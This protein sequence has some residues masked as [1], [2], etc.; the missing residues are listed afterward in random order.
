MIRDKKNV[1]LFSGQGSQYY[2][3]TRQLYENDEVFRNSMKELNQKF[4][5][6][7]H[8]D[9]ISEL[10]CS[11]DRKYK[12]FD[13]TLYT[14]PCIFMCE[15]SIVKALH[16]KGVLPDV[17]IG[18][19]LG[20]V[21]AAVVAGMI[22]EDEG[23]EIVLNQTLAV[24]DN[25]KNGTLLAIVCDPKYF[26]ENEIFNNVE[27][28]S[29]NNNEHFVVSGEISEIN[30]ISNYL[31]QEGILG[32]PIPVIHAFHSRLID[33]GREQ[34]LNNTKAI[35][36]KRPKIPFLSCSSGKFET[37]LTTEFFWNAIRKTIQFKKTIEF[38][39]Q[40]C[41]FNFIDVGPGGTLAGFI[42]RILPYPNNLNVFF[43]ES[44]L[45]KADSIL[46]NIDI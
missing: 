7:L 21:G 3:M 23:V 16:Y 29:V 26:Y 19:S 43:I 14:H 4:S 6:K 28:A 13:N 5:E 46:S 32:V 20:E 40:I 30:K 35:K 41:E 33:N 38:I 31:K 44:P 9:I 22:S 15:I 24:N 34:Y 10:Y 39:Y 27:M 12:M 11:D 1:F 17:V 37:P 25:C 8:K 42:R 45:K 36:L 2:N 18:T